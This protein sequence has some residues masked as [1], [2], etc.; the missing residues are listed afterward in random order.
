MCGQRRCQ[1]SCMADA[2]HQPAGT[3]SCPHARACRAATRLLAAADAGN[4]PNNHT[5]VINTAAHAGSG[6][7]IGC[8]MGASARSQVRYST[9]PSQVRLL[10]RSKPPQPSRT[11]DR[12]VMARITTYSEHKT[13]RHALLPAEGHTQ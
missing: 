4:N 8:T 10:A 13:R 11:L 5:A 9:K 6:T 3:A 2:W 7:A 12:L 1:L